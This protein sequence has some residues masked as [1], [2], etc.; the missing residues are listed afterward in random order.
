MTTNHP[1][2]GF[3]SKVIFVLIA[4][5]SIALGLSALH[6]FL[7]LRDLRTDYL[8]NRGRLIATTTVREIRGPERQTNLERWKTIKKAVSQTI[9][10]FGGTISHQHGVGVDH[11]PYLEAEKGPVGIGILRHL[12]V[13]T[14]PE[15]RMNPSKLLS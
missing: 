15:K 5:I 10:K 13:H 14:D 11:K 6:T 12:F 4:A 3:P 2:E 8:E 7:T 9:V 1:R